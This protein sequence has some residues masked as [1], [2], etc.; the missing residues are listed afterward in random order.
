MW[1]VPQTQTLTKT[2]PAAMTIYHDP[3]RSDQKRQYGAHFFYP[4]A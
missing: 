2:K 1:G 4:S 3:K